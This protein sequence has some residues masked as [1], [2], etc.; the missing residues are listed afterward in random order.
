M[1]RLPQPVCTANRDAGR[2][3][4]HFSNDVGEVR[5]QE[6]F[7]SFLDQGPQGRMRNAA[8]LHEGQLRS[9]VPL[10][11]RH[12]DLIMLLGVE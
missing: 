6:V 4:R 11:R 2:L 10:L 3:T 7:M 12:A 9:L 1:R 5:G 8:T